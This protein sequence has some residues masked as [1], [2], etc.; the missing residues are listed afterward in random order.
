[1]NISRKD[2]K[3]LIHCATNNIRDFVTNEDDFIDDFLKS[4][5]NKEVFTD[6]NTCLDNGKLK[7][8]R[9]DTTTVK[10]VWF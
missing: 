8:E 6:T 5:G 1:M 7:K 10:V 3:K 4:V 2:L 9:P